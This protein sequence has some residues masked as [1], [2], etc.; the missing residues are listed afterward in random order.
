PDLPEDHLL[1][2]GPSRVHVAPGQRARQLEEHPAGG[3][4]GRADE[5]A[6]EHGAREEQDRPAHEE[7]GAARCRGP[8]HGAGVSAGTLETIPAT[9]RNRSTTRGPQRLA[10]SSST[11][12]TRSSSTAVSSSQPG[13]SA[14]DSGVTPQHCA[15]ARRMRSG[16]ASRS[17]SSDSCG[18]GL[19]PVA[20]EVSPSSE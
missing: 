6:G 12:W 13:R 17:S 10:R 11:T 4:P 9:S 18:Y 3:E 2:R 14:T 15:S 8:A 20:T 16:S 7:G 1:L 5:D 19:S